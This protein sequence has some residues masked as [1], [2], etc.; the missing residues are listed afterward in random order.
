MYEG[1]DGQS[2]S[3]QSGWKAVPQSRTGGREA[4]IAKFIM[5]SW[6]GSDNVMHTGLSRRTFAVVRSNA[7]VTSSAVETQ[8]LSTVVNVNLTIH[9]SPAVDTDTQV[10]TLLIVARRTVLTR[11]QRRTLVNVHR[12]VPTYT[13]Q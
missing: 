3:P 12:A 9:S 13:S 2:R 8:S 7:V 11:T 4:P 5:C 10:A 1:V 6:H